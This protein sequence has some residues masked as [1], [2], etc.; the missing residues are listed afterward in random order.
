[1]HND[2]G[3]GSAFLS[4]GE[5]AVPPRFRQLA[6]VL[7][8]PPLD[9]SKLFQN[10]CFFT[11]LLWVLG[12]LTLCAVL[13]VVRLI[14]ERWPR[15][16]AINLVVLSWL[17]IAVVQAITSILYSVTV[18]DFLGQLHNLV[19]FA[20][21][22]WIF[23]AMIIA[24]GSAQRLAD[25]RTVRAVCWLGIYMLALSA[26]AVPLKLLGFTPAGFQMT[27][28]GLLLPE[29]PAARFY[30]SVV[31]FMQED[32]F[33][34][35]TSRLMLFFPWYTAL[36]L[37]GLSVVFIS[38]L[39]RNWKWRWVSV[40]GGVVATVF[41]WSRIA[42]VCLV[43]VGAFSIF[44]KLPR[45]VKILSVCAVLVVFYGALIQ[46]F[47][48]ITEYDRLQGDVDAARPGSN[49]ARDLIYAKSWDGFLQSPY[50]GNG[51]NFPQALKT[52]PIAIG[53]HSTTYGLLYTA[54]APGLVAFVIAMLVT[55]LALLH[56]Y[57]TTAAGSRER[58]FIG[59]GL[60]LVACLVLYCKF[61]ALYSL[62][63][64]CIVLFAWIGACLPS[65]PL[66]VH[67]RRVASE[68]SGPLLPDGPTRSLSTMVDCPAEANAPRA[69]STTPMPSAGRNLRALSLFKVP[70]P[71]RR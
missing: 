58:R 14:W 49:E 39:E 5:P 31:I 45:V 2:R 54:G 25:E 13:M 3:S 60:S 22:G 28:I 63:L 15:G 59:A 34:E 36:G 40:L 68:T 19:S 21:V 7:S 23:G 50:F 57:L 32:T 8:R 71:R 6:S 4:A 1:M 20:V 17:S 12:A 41:S 52:E 65:P 47:D 29:S 35:K 67:R 16:V 53:S 30:T 48:P 11:P 26:L 18:G 27:P 66:A 51:L 37:G 9:G 61:E 33:G 55:F 70:Q 42:I 64:P 46:G 44:L 10:F 24:V 38:A 43:L 56:R 69:L 62:T